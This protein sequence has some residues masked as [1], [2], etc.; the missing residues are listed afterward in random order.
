[1]KPVD[2]TRFAIEL[3]LTEAPGNCYQACFA[4]LLELKLEDV[5][6]EADYWEP[7]M[8]HRASWRLYFPAL[9]NWLLARGYTLIETEKFAYHGQPPY[10]ILCGPSPRNRD[11]TH[12]VVGRGHEIVH[13]PHPSRD[14]LLKTGSPWYSELLIPLL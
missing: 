12:A 13:D 7:R 9:M 8:D 14:G 5:P 2:Q 3:P 6:D 4:S 1:M 10:C 11:V